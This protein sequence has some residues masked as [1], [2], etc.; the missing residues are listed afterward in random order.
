MPIIGKIC[1]KGVWDET[2]P[3]ITFDENGICNYAH[4]FDTL[5]QAY[6]RGDIGNAI[7][8]NLIQKIKKKGRNNKY[9]CIIGVSGGT[10]S[11]YLLHLAIIIYT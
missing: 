4:L 11:S 6:P 2:V 9:D 10:D 5:V 7:W 3:E 1:K 8:D